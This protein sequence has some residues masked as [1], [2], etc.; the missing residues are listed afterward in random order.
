MEDW[1]T[2]DLLEQ[3]AAWYSAH[4][5]SFPIILLSAF[6]LVML[7]TVLFFFKDKL[8]HGI[9]VGIVAVIFFAMTFG[10]SPYGQ[11]LYLN[12]STAMLMAL[13]IWF[14]AS[15]AEMTEGW[16]MPVALA[17]LVGFVSLFLVNVEAPQSSFFLNISAGLVG[18]VTTAFLIREDW[19]WSP[20]KRGQ[21]LREAIRK[22]RKV[23]RK[24]EGKT[25]DYYILIVGRDAADTGQ[26]LQFLH[27]SNIMTY[28][29]QE[30][31]YD[32]ETGLTFQQ[33]QANIV[34]VVKEPEVVFLSNQE[35]RL[36]ILAYPDSAKKLYKQ[37]TEVL[38]ITN[39]QRIEWHSEDLLHLELQANAPQQL[40]SQYL[41]KQIYSLAQEWRSSEDESLHDAIDP[42]LEWAKEMEFIE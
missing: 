16:M 3:I 28:D 37:L 33:V 6:A 2:R 21:A 10:T 23:D 17:A 36:R 40:F 30:P 24:A 34:T 4:I 9:A 20:Q 39:Q 8:F 1:I 42:L 27:D 41:E 31:A 25:G 5:E 12:L 15:L 32:K 18:A 35:A 38:E 14:I 19:Q 7:G 13:V 26:K 29:V 11:E 22:E